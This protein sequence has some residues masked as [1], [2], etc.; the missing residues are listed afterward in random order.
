MFVREFHRTL[1][2]RIKRYGTTI[3]SQRTI[4]LFLTFPL[5][6]RTLTARIMEILAASWHI[7]LNHAEKFIQ[8]NKL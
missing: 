7:K 4:F 2:K 3:F 5:Q 6:K 8:S 1:G